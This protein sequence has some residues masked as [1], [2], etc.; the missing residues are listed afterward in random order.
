MRA[1]EEARGDGA[2]EGD[3][4]DFGPVVAVPV[5]VDV[6][7]VF[8][9]MAAESVSFTP[10]LVNALQFVAFSLSVSFNA[11]LVTVLP[12]HPAIGTVAVIVCAL[13]VGVRPGSELATPVSDLQ[14]T[15]LRRPGAAE[16]TP[17]GVSN[18]ITIAN[19]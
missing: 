11:A 1:L 19:R 7:A 15:R 6:S 2:G 18:A 13:F 16:S 4:T 3:L 8:Q 9:V 10:V 17:T 12:L 14:T 5:T